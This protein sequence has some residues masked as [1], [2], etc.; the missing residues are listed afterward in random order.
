MSLIAALATLQNL[1]SPTK[2]HALQFAFACVL[3]ETLENQTRNQT[4]PPAKQ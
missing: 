2:C 4:E 1:G 3:S